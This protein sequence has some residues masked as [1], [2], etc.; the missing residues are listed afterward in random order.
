MKFALVPVK[1]LSKAKE[2]LSPILSQRERSALA[3][4]MLED[5]L[6]ALKGSRLLDRLFVVTSDENAIEI[7]TR[8]GAEII[9]EKSQE[10]ESRSVDY[11]S[12]ICKDMGAESV[13]VIP[14][15]A[16]LVTSQ[17]VDFILEKEKPYSSVILVPSRDEMGTNAILRK[18]PDA[19]PS[20]FGY[21]SFRKHIGEAKQKNIPYEIHKIPSIALDIDEPEDLMLLISQEST[22]NTYRELLRMGI[23]QK[24][25]SI[26]EL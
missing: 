16:P 7:A 17:D 5:V 3:H 21:D 15:D 12:V 10:G 4:A 13:L 11:A 22:T 18:P 8:L 2:R 25:S 26:V 1:D 14:G 9:K 19:I 20:R 23:S 24:V 6:M